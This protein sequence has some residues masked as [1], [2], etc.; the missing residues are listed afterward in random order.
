MCTVPDI[1]NYMTLNDCLFAFIDETQHN[2]LDSLIG[3]F[4]IF[5]NSYLTLIFDKKYI[6]V[7]LK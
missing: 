2:L 4:V 7:K 5:N 1:L 3:L 6:P